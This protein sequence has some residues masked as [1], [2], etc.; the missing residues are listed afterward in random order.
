[1]EKTCPPSAHPAAGG[2]PRYAGGPASPSPAPLS[3]STQQGSYQLG[4]GKDAGYLKGYL[5]VKDEAACCKRCV[6]FKG[7]SLFNF[8]P[9]GTRGG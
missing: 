8:C 4:P 3:C 2:G 9:S 1:M 5:Y 6:D 7:C